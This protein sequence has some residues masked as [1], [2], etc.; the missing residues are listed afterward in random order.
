MDLEYLTVD[1]EYEF[2]RR[3]REEEEMA[4]EEEAE[5]EFLEE[6]DY[7]SRL[8]VSYPQDS[9]ARVAQF[10]LEKYGEWV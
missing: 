10:W 3:R 6:R 5:R 8:A 1:E 7:Q 4:E 2:E 9:R